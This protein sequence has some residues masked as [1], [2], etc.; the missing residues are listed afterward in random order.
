M[1]TLVIRRTK[2]HADPSN[3]EE[4][5]QN[6]LYEIMHTP[7]I[8]RT[9]MLTEAQKEIAG[10]K[11]EEKEQ[12]NAEK[13]FLKRMGIADGKKKTWL[14]M[15]EKNAKE[16]GKFSVFSEAMVDTARE[17][18]NAALRE[19]YKVSD[20]AGYG[21]ITESHPTI[22]KSGMSEALEKR[23][24]EAEVAKRTE[25]Q[26]IEAG[27][28]ED[29]APE[30]IFEVPPGPGSEQESIDRLGKIGGAMDRAL[31]RGAITKEKYDADVKEI[32]KGA[33]GEERLRRARTVLQA[34]PEI[35]RILEAELLTQREAQAPISIP[36]SIESIAGA[37]T[38]PDVLP[39]EA[40]EERPPSLP[41]MLT[42]QD[43]L[44]GVPKHLGRFIGRGDA[45]VKVE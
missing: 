39:G 2:Y 25:T 17:E 9:R 4:E 35:M 28:F 18:Y 21:D 29:V 1:L 14:M 38:L 42:P 36:Q 33:T 20:K 15:E 32:T 24:E 6:R 34:T 11:A 3:K 27:P 19:A 40:P 8:I 10:G 7:E 30:V 26:R 12:A 23:L 43:E 5:S 44:G 13:S 16:G 37:A 31:A 22:S 41:G 45:I